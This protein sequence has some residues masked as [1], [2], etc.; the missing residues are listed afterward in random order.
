MFYAHSPLKFNGPVRTHINYII[1]VTQMIFKYAL[2][3]S[4]GGMV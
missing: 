1:I 3:M 4:E 2:A